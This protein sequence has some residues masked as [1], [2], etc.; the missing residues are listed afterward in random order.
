[1]ATVNPDALNVL[2]LQQAEDACRIIDAIGF[3]SNRL[4]ATDAAT[5]LNKA[6]SELKADYG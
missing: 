3:V 6:R 4:G 5:E 1:M 2:T